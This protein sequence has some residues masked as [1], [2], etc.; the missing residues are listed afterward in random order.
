[1]VIGYTVAWWMIGLPPPP[2]DDPDDDE[3]NCPV[4]AS[5]ATT[6]TAARAVSASSRYSVYLQGCS[7]KRSLQVR[8]WPCLWPPPLM[9]WARGGMR[10]DDRTCWCGAD[11]DRTGIGAIFW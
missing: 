1:M 3:L 5:A 7:E 4:P 9:G 8:S 2:P 11:D 6:T 10:T